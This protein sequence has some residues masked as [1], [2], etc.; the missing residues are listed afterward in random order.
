MMRIC[1]NNITDQIR[2]LFDANPLKVP[3]AR[4]QPLCMLEVKEQKPKY[5]GEFRFLVKDG[6]QHNIEIKTSPVSQVSNV[7]TKKIDFKIGFD[8]LGNF[9]KAFG[10][11]PAAVGASIKGT[12]KLS[13]SFGNVIRKYIDTLELGHILVSNDITGDP[14]NMFIEEITQNKDVKLALITDVLTS[15]DFSLSTYR[16]NTT[17]TEINIPLIQQYLANID[18]N[19]TVEKVSENEIK[20]KGE[21]PLTYAFTCVEITIDP[22]TGKFSRGQW[23]DNIRSAQ[24]PGFGGTETVDIPKL[25]LDE[26]QANPLLIDF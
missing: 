12:K 25:L 2:D 8:I 15:T 19:L 14:D 18:T 17:G 3:E 24:A 26:N 5:L 13:F 10:L 21:T 7:K 9:I 1:K 23:L 4:I 20:F 11:D 16:D 6:F 22:E